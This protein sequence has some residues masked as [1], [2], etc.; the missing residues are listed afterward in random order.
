LGDSA[1]GEGKIGNKGILIEDFSGVS[2][3]NRQFDPIDFKGC[4]A[5]IQGYLIQVAVSRALMKPSIPRADGKAREVPRLLKGSHPLIKGFV[6]I[7]FTDQ[8]EVKPIPE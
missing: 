3:G 6:R 7:G 5:A 4:F 2:A 8:D 1:P